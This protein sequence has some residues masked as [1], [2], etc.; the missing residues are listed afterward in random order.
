[1]NG[2]PMKSGKKH[3]VVMT[4]GQTYR[5]YMADLCGTIS[6]EILIN[7]TP[8]GCSLNE[9]LSFMMHPFDQRNLDSLYF[10]DFLTEDIY[11]AI[12]YPSKSL[13]F[14]NPAWHTDYTRSWGVNEQIHEQKILW[15]HLR[16]YIL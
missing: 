15:H 12:V 7:S 2:I 4:D 14:S 5:L 3:N 13:P 9:F 10:L 16:R 6:T 11:Y 1:M 8:N